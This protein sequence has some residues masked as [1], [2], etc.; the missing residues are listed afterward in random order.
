MVTSHRLCHFLLG[1]EAEQKRSD[2]EEVALVL[3]KGLQGLNT[4]FQN[5]LNMTHT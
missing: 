4:S 1:Q 3:A 5:H 2:K